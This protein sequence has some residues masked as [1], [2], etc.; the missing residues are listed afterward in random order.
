MGPSPIV[1]RSSSHAMEGSWTA[2]SITR[3]MAA[4]IKW[5]YALPKD[6]G[7]R[8]E[9]R[10]LLRQLLALGFRREKKNGDSHQEQETQD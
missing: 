10:L 4:S 8:S 2:R 6:A 3:S 5:L 9:P 7:S 1:R